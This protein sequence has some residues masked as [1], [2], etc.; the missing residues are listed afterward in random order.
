MQQHHNSL[1][2]FQNRSILYKRQRLGTGRFLYKVLVITNTMALQLTW[3][4]LT[5]EPVVMSR[6]QTVVTKPGRCELNSSS[7]FWAYIVIFSQICAFTC[8]SS[9]ASS[10]PYNQSQHCIHCSSASSW[11]Y[12]QP[13]HSIQQQH[14][15]LVN[16]QLKKQVNHKKCFHNFSWW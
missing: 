12:N 16:L 7:Y 6:F 4:Y 13:Q 5:C 2:N 15:L 14:C 8:S 1:A 3:S 10:W 9:P 11:P